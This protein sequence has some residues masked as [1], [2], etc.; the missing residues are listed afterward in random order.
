LSSLTLLKVKSLPKQIK[1]TL[2]K[3]KGKPPIYKHYG[4]LEQ[5]MKEIK[6]PFNK[7][8]L[9]RIKQSRYKDKFRK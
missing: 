5:T 3:E 1:R 2:G 9:K 4:I 6:P 8:T 7:K